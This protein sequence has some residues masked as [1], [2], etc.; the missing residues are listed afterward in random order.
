MIFLYLLTRYPWDESVVEAKKGR[1]RV[2]QWQQTICLVISAGSWDMQCVI[3]SASEGALAYL[4]DERPVVPCRSKIPQIS[5]HNKIGMHVSSP[6]ASTT[7]IKN[8]SSK[9]AG[10][11]PEQGCSQGRTFPDHYTF[12][13]LCTFFF[14]R[15]VFFFLVS[16]FLIRVLWCSRF[17]FFSFPLAFS[18]VLHQRTWRS[19]PSNTSSRFHDGPSSPW[20]GH[21]S[22]NG[23]EN[24]NKKH[25]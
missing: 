2:L 14:C 17:C 11:W 20:Y 1:K 13:F 19:L 3:L 22:R 15:K 9:S 8:H 6:A 10:K 25:V 23:Q 7:S 24:T 5:Q 16:F 12:T 21:C 18:C 4:G